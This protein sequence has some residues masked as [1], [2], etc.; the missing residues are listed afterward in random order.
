MEEIQDPEE[1]ATYIIV[2]NDLNMSKGKIASQVG[3]LTETIA[4]KIMKTMYESVKSKE[5]VLDYMKYAKTGRK[6]IILKGTQQELEELSK[7]KDAEFIIDAGR[8]EIAPGSLTVVGFPPSNKNKD[9]FK[10]FRL[11]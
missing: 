11:L 2:N 8:T 10:K 3:H 7:E 1:Y 4:E 9:R 6:K 5:I